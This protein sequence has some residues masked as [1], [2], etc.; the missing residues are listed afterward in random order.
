MPRA[1]GHPHL[2]ACCSWNGWIPR[3]RC[4]HWNPEIIDRAGGVEVLGQAG[5][6]SR[7]LTWK[8][9]A[10]AQPEVVIVAPCGFTL[11]RAELELRAVEHRL[12]WRD[13][14]AVRQG[15]WFWPT[16]QPSSRGPA[17]AWKPASASPPRPSIPSDAPACPPRGPGLAAVAGKAV[18]GEPARRYGSLDVR[19]QIPISSRCQ[20]LRGISYLGTILERSR[21]RGWF[22]PRRDPA[23][24]AKAGEQC[25]SH[26]QEKE[27]GHRQGI[28]IDADFGHSGQH[29]GRGHG[30]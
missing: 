16:D 3:F 10:A 17:H 24:V 13:L 25:D 29:Q 14:P 5:V 11:E 28:P 21:G 1:A 19:C 4:G 23:Q 9:V 20:N 15:P 12:E 30:D 22:I 7:R 26:R 27:C 8:Q 18:R 2:A 6:P